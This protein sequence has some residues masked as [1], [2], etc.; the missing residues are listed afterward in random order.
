MG[1]SP[2]AVQPY[3]AQAPHGGGSRPGTQVPDGN[4]GGCPDAGR[5]TAGRSGK[6]ADGAQ[7]AELLTGTSRGR[8]C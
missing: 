6:R 1:A 2:F 7:A 5:R 3:G 8:G 4:G